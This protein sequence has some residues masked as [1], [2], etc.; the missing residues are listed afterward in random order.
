MRA[1]AKN[2]SKD[3]SLFRDFRFSRLGISSDLV[4]EE[5]QVVGLRLWLDLFW[6]WLGPLIDARFVRV[7]LH[8][9]VALDLG[10]RRQETCHICANK[11]KKQHCQLLS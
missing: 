8:L 4:H 10:G 5:R 9:H 6:V 1:G 7:E 3:D 2:I 11:D